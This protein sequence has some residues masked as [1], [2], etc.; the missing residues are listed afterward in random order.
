P[1]ETVLVADPGT[2]TPYIGAQYVLPKPGRWTVIPRAHGGLGYALPA[3][4][5]AHYGRPEARTISLMG[6][7]S[8]GMSVGELETISRLNLPLT[9]IHFNNGAFGWIKELQHL[10]HDQRYFSVDFNP[11]DY[12][13]IARG[14]GLRAWQVTDP[15]DL[16]NALRQALDFGGPAF[17]DIVTESQLTE[18]PPVQ[19]WL[20]A[21]A[22]VG[23]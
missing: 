17:V 16:E 15:A 11:V 14:F 7:G 18:T 12:A 2:P 4:V 6:D 21:V 9:L 23:E 20:D 3:V 5:G 1:E 22:R 19:A 13:G 10:Y 8:F